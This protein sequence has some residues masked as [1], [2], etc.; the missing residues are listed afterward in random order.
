V[1]NPAGVQFLVA[2]SSNGE[3][4]ARAIG[5]SIDV[6]RSGHDSVEWRLERGHRETVTAIAFSA[7]GSTLASG[8]TDGT[9]RLWDLERGVATLTLRGPQAAVSALEFSRD[10]RRLAAGGADATVFVWDVVR[11]TVRPTERIETTISSSCVGFS[12]EPA[13]LAVDSGGTLTV[14]HPSD[15]LPATATTIGSVRSCGIS[16]KGKVL[17]AVDSGAH[18]VL[19]DARTGDVRGRTSPVANPESV[20]LSAD[21][22]VVAAHV[23][24]GAFAVWDA[25]TGKR[26]A[27]IDVDGILEGPF[28][29]MSNGLVVAQFRNDQRSSV[30]VWDTE[31]A[32]R[33]SLTATTAWRYHAQSAV[34]SAKQLLASTDGGDLRIVDL[35]AGTLKRQLAW[36]IGDSF[37][38]SN[39]ATVIAFSPDC[40]VVA[41]GDLFGQISLWEIASGANRYRVAAHSGLQVVQWRDGRGFGTRTSHNADGVAALEF[42]PDG[43]TLASGGGTAAGRGELKLWDAAR[44]S[45]LAT[46]PAEGGAVKRVMFSAS[47]YQLGVSLQR[48]RQDVR[49]GATLLEVWN[50]QGPERALLAADTAAITRLTFSPDGSHLISE[51]TA[52]KSW[53]LARNALERV[54]P[55]PPS[56]D[57]EA[58]RR[59]PRARTRRGEEVF[60]SEDVLFVDRGAGAPIFRLDS[61]DEAHDFHAEPI[62]ALHLMADGRLASQ[63][64]YG[65]VK[66]RPAEIILWDLT[67]GRAIT[68]AFEPSNVVTSF[69]FSP[70]ERTFVTAGALGPAAG[71][72]GFVHIWDA[73]RF[74]L[75]AALPDHAALVTAVAFSSDGKTLA[76]GDA[77]GFVRIWGLTR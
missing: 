57:D 35:G 12:L 64:G 61:A 32:R 22:D 77:N 4:I 55:P 3:R 56:L 53:N 16:R 26:R 58:T 45:L 59:G 40:S 11:P 67:S 43:R 20:R 66:E 17:F 14:R 60:A 31:S 19:I 1:P 7:D 50:A 2:L 39:E 36:R 74:T 51:G 48:T 34:C 75:I 25:M 65:N 33:L 21:G 70:D 37:M 27:L 44:G 5:T 15:G 28:E 52:T 9:V 41:V 62:A 6:W 46:L 42:S 47:G 8:G 71:H 18:L 30:G 73:Q 63:G 76:T 72:P 54:S 68:H 24:P 38:S 49:N 69:V 13:S 10:G 23:G 29:L